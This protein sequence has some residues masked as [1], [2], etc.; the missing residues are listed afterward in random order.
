MEQMIEQVGGL[1]V[2]KQSVVACVRVPGASGTR[3]QHT[4]TF[5]TTAAELSM[6]RDWLQE[7]HHR[8]QGF[9]DH[10]ASIVVR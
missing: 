10:L 1:D 8:Q 7:H 5:G 3:Q 2:H 6:L 9:P 4:R